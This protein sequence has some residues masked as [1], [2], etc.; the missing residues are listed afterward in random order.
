MNNQPNGKPPRNPADDDPIGTAVGAQRRTRI[1]PN[2]I[3]L[4]LATVARVPAV[5]LVAR[6]K[7]TSNLFD[8]SEARYVLIL[9]SVVSAAD[10]NRGA[11]PENP[12]AARVL[13]ETKI[14]VEI[15]SDVMRDYYSASVERQVLSDG[16]LLDTI[17]ALPLTADVENMGVSLLA[18]FVMERKVSDPFRRAMSGLSS[19]DTLLNPAALISVIESHARDVAGIGS[20]P[21]SAAVVDDIDWRPQGALLTST[22]IPWLDEMLGGGHASGEA[23]VLLGCTSGGKTALAVQLAMEGA[24]FQASIA[25]DIGPIEAGHWYYFSWEL[26]EDEV[27]ERVY[28]YGARIHHE[29]FN[30]KPLRPLTSSDDPNSLHEYEFDPYVNSPGN[31]VM[32]ERE[33]MKALNKRL[34]G[35]NNRLWIVDYSGK[36]PGQ[37][38]GGVEEVA[39]YLRRERMRGRKVAGVVIDYA[40]LAV[41]RLIGARKLRPDAEYPLL[42]KFIDEVRNQISIPMA[43]PSWVLHQFHGDVNKKAPGTRVHHSEARGSRNFADNCDFAFGLSPYN[44]TTGL[45][46]VTMSKH[47]RAKGREDDTV[48][49]FD[50]RFGAFLSPDLEYVV[51]PQTRQIV[52]RDYVETLPVRPVKGALPPVNPMDGM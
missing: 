1:T 31:P 6:Y 15:A 38:L 17:F 48:V 12:D 22:K 26:S 44:K 47:R 3:T 8:P 36:K 10:D 21:G 27:R 39:A 42:S 41:G 5:F 37:G 30:N 45:L 19:Q 34:S 29:T 51:D 49:R 32:G 28:A 9:R 24:E 7:L 4:M 14:G 50:G 16:G 46:T 20:D 43:C 52:P 13:V 33:R 40:G 23:Y 11:L 18:R 2:E 25:A 35:P